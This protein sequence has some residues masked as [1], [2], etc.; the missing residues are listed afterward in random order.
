MVFQ[1]LLVAVLSFCI[2]SFSINVAAQADSPATRPVT[3]PANAP[4]PS[5]VSETNY[6]YNRTWSPI[7]RKYSGLD[8]NVSFVLP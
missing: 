3:A 4:G 1:M 7:E 8:V 6:V 5:L 2:V